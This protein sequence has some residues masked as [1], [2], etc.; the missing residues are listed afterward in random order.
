MLLLLSISFAI[1]AFATQVVKRA[2]DG[3]PDFVVKYAPMVFL[4]S[5]D[6][7]KP[8]DIS[9][10]LNNTE[11]RVDFKVVSQQPTTL[12]NLSFL[13]NLGGSNVYLTSK[14]KPYASPVPGYLFG[15]LPNGEG[16]TEGAVS[17]T[18]IVNDHGDGTV[19]AF[20]FYFYAF[21]RG[22][23]SIGNHVGDWEHSMIRFVN[24]TPSALW[25]SQH[26]AGQAFKYSA[27]QKYQDGVGSL[28]VNIN[29]QDKCRRVSKLTLR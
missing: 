22:A 16:K 20:Y 17:S 15:V 11:P 21:D 28:R 27:V 1:C 10:Q 6:P 3:V 9:T 26:S 23:L 14:I 25:Y 2:P 7:W 29:Y 18:I 12:D 19:D 4:Y 8:S 13:N 5:E 24:K